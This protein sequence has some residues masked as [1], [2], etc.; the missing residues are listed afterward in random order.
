MN[1][2]SISLIAAIIF[3]LSVFSQGISLED[4]KLCAKNFYFERINQNQ[5]HDYDVVSI[6]HVYIH[7]NT[8][9][10]LYYMIV[11]DNGGWVMVSGTK[12]TVPVLAYSLTN[13][14]SSTTTPPQFEAWVNQYSDQIDYSIRE[15]SVHP[16]AM[17]QWA[18]YLTTNY[19]TIKP[20]SKEKSLEPMLNSTW[21]QGN[22]YNGQCPD[23]PGGPAGHCLT[24]CVATAMG[25]LCYYFR[26]PTSG[27]GSYSY[28][29]ENYGTISANFE[30]SEYDYH[31]MV[32]NVTSSTP[33]VAELLFHL[34]VSVDMVY[35]PDGSGMYNHKAAYSLRTHFKFNPETE[36]LYRDSTNINWD[37]TI[38]AH[39]DMG[40]PMYYAGW[41]VPNLYGHA[42]IVDGYQTEDF[43]HFNWGW[44]GYLDG[45][46]YLEELSPGGN[47]FNLAQ[48]LI[49]NAY[50]DTM[51]YNYPTFC[52][53]EETLTAINGTLTDGSGPFNNYENNSS[54]SWLVD[55]QSVYDSVN[56]ITLEFNRL[57]TV[58][59][60]DIITIYDGPTINDAVLGI[61]S[62]N[63]IPQI[64]TS[65]GNKVLVTFETDD[66]ETDTGW[67][68][69]YESN[70]EQWCNGLTNLFEP[71]DIVSDGSG[72]F[73]Y[74]NGSTCMWYIQPP[75][76]T[77]ITLSFSEF[78][79]EPDEDLVK[80]YD[81]A[82][83]TLLGTYSGFELPP[84][85][86]IESS[87]MMISFT[88]NSAETFQGW[89][90]VYEINTISVDE[91]KN[92]E[93]S[94]SIYPN[95]A[96]ESIY[97]NFNK[98]FDSNTILTLREITG[99]LI[100]NKS[101]APFSGKEKI[102]TDNLVEGV[103]LI[104]LKNSS[105]VFNK[106]IIIRK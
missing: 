66:T 71:T 58:E 38:L 57:N 39:L 74:R 48:E 65:S 106:K 13:N 70:T 80:I 81:A 31:Q 6:E 29:L 51:N 44:G 5:N 33:E 52:A 19:K 50:P 104:E 60:L 86:A 22:Y 2:R 47:N 28:E 49:I 103:Y 23:D 69:N 72:D 53:G 15:N 83:N 26:W 97:I 84:V 94:I 59:N 16:E 67:F 8:E 43:F 90:A 42:F 85:I 45:Y 56:N 54:C 10:C 3:S 9:H 64:I 82:T 99:K 105:M 32:N 4:A 79:T 91:N 27:V 37:S 73:Y 75:G 93:N 1:I 55:P 68:L 100:V 77:S 98:P 30:D 25:Q 46:F 88:S 63:T 61:F 76:A 62:G 12:N 35:G 92:A 78:E 11:M 20:L 21:D 95:P 18:Y 24:G 7:E 14:Y 87:K 101:L 34:G 17:K 96:T 36:Y 102:N 89:K 41:S 40:V